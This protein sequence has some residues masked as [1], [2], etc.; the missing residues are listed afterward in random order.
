MCVKQFPGTS[1]MEKL[2]ECKHRYAHSLWLRKEKRTTKQCLSS[3]VRSICV[4]QTHTPQKKW[5]ISVSL[6]QRKEAPG[7][8]PKGGAS[9]QGTLG[10]T[11]GSV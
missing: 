3:L 10:F 4:P 11:L 6:K 1:P 9:M 2:Q 5:S 8:C 7:P